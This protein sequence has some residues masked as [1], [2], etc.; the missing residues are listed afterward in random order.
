[1]TETLTATM[2]VADVLLRRPLAARILVNHHM[3]CVGCAIAPFETLVEAC[4][5]YGISIGDLL[6]ELNATTMESS[7][8]ETLAKSDD[9]Q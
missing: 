7:G 5:I 6:A 1:M 2:T 8:P 3:H 9:R 4:E